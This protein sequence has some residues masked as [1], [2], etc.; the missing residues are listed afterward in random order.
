MT[1]TITKPANG[2]VLSVDNLDGVL[3]PIGASGRVKYTC[4][5]VSKKYLVLGAN[6]GS[7]YFFERKPNALLTNETLQSNFEI[8]SLNEIRDSIFSIK[9]APCNDNL[10][11]M[12]T[13]K[14]I[15]VIEPN[16]A[17]DKGRRREK[18]KQLFKIIDHPREAEI[19]TI[20]WSACGG[21]LF[22]GDDLGNI[23]CSSVA[24]GRSSHFIL[25]FSADFVTKCDSRLVQLDVIPTTVADTFSILA[26]SLTKSVVINYTISHSQTG[27]VISQIQVGKKLREKPT[28]Q[29]ACYHP[30]HNSSIYASR[31]GKRIWL[32][33]PV[34]GTVLST[35]N[36]KSGGEEGSVVVT[37]VPLAADTVNTP[38]LPVTA[39]AFA[40]LLPYGMNLISWDEKSLILIDV[41]EVEVIEWRVDST[42]IQDICI[43]ENAIYILHGQHR[44]ISR[45][46]SQ[47]LI[48]ALPIPTTITA[49]VEE[50]HS[51]QQQQPQ[52][53]KPEEIHSEPIQ[54]KQQ[55]QPQQSYVNTL[56]FSVVESDDSKDT[57]ATY[58]DQTSNKDTDGSQLDSLDT[59]SLTNSTSSLTIDDTNEQNQ[60]SVLPPST[61][62]TATITTP[63][64][65]SI[66]T[67]TPTPATTTTTPPPA[68][69]SSQHVRNTSK[70]NIFSEIE[71]NT[72][73]LITTTSSGVTK[74]II[75]KKKAKTSDSST[76][77]LKTSGSDA[78]TPSPV[79]P[80]NNDQTATISIAKDPSTQASSWAN[81]NVFDEVQ[82][83][84]NSP[85]EPSLD[86]KHTT[87]TTVKRTV[88]KK[89]L[90]KKEKTNTSSSSINDS[91]SSLST[92]ENTSKPASPTKPEQPPHPQPIQEPTTTATPSLSHPP[93]PIQPPHPTQET[94]A[95]TPQ[96]PI[97]AAASKA[98]GIFK[99]LSTSI[100]SIQQKAIT[101]I[102]KQTSEIKSE[103]TS[104]T[105]KLPF[106]SNSSTPASST[107]PTMEP[108]VEHTTESTPTVAASA[109]TPAPIQ[110]VEPIPEPTP[111]E[112]LEKLTKGTYDSWI[113]Y[114]FKRNEKAF[115]PMLQ[116]WLQSFYKVEYVAPSEMINEIITGCFL[117]GVNMLV[118]DPTGKLC[119][120]W[121]ESS[122]RETIRKYFTYLD[123]NKVYPYVNERQWDSCI[124]TILEMEAFSKHGS[125]VIS[126]L[127]S[128]IDNND[129]QG[130]IH[131]LETQKDDVGLLFRYMERLFEL[132]PK[133]AATFYAN[134]YPVILPRNIVKL[135]DQ[136]P[137]VRLPIK[138]EYLNQLLELVEECKYDSNL[139]EEW[140]TCNLS[141]NQPPKD[142]LFTNEHRP[143]VGAH[144]VEWK[145]AQQLLSIIGGV[146]TNEYLCD[147]SKLE[148]LCESNGFFEGL[149]SI[150]LHHY[151]Q[152]SSK[153]VTFHEQASLE[154]ARKLVHLVVSTDNVDGLTNL[155]ENNIDV[156]LWSMLVTKMQEHRDHYF[157]VF[158]SRDTKFAISEVLVATMMGRSI[159]P[160]QTIDILIASPLF[161]STQIPSNLLSEWVRNG[162]WALYNRKSIS[163]E[164]LSRLD[165]YLWTKKP[166]NLSPQIWS[167]VDQD[168]NNFHSPNSLKSQQQ[169]Q[170][171]QL[172][173]SSSSI[174]SST[175]NELNLGITPQFFEDSSFH[176]GTET[177]IHSG[178]CPICTLPLVE[179]P[180]STFVG[181]TPS[182]VVI[183]PY[184]GHS[185]HQYCIEEQGCLL[186]YSQKR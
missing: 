12:A 175:A 90:V 72:N 130:C 156:G 69:S 147:L 114:K 93:Q 83:K 136:N 115:F 16:L 98:S 64:N 37:P 53:Q 129:G 66:P 15:Y 73:P 68:A 1:T 33:D 2:Y 102:Q 27:K 56:T 106:G 52:Q 20:V 71:V 166:M 63:P 18:E 42:A 164:I 61:A 70:E 78:V 57:T 104:I 154:Y 124:D 133:Q 86:P 135:V 32:A 96:Q 60:E 157:N 74:K 6:T 144:N 168:F 158:Y 131:Y 21:Y 92:P 9:L 138:F 50:H 141:F 99:G 160:L 132:Q 162:K 17:A 89:K 107:P 80:T 155:M 125:K 116:I 177:E 146:M 55:Q 4:F 122:A 108:I 101:K 8:L 5:D 84:G 58:S 112:V 34:E 170:N 185:Y 88:V 172:I 174:T 126:T 85:M 140:F 76:N 110:P 148:D 13:N 150:Y 67:V 178:Q 62:T 38:M 103:L 182:S 31:P 65:V 139:V 46:Y 7:L 28:K 97:S 19:T 171:N 82:S 152:Y 45:V 143:R 118:Q 3:A 145:N 121:N 169:Q 10:V 184:C 29:G 30:L 14:I 100:E 75:K 79:S 51:T 149:L 41:D 109:P 25:R 95:Q 22:S 173:D 119:M 94:S 180:E 81:V 87:T 77:L 179:N 40:R 159:G 35:M 161:E 123:C 181:V 151:K 167:L 113:I 120:C 43:H 137:S 105:Q 47:T 117:C 11:A 49:A 39:M 48:S 36:F 23:Y 134:R 165:S 44:S 186:C 91:A 142:Q 111:L 163:H 183:F 176:W 127:N 59:N 128:F 153:S 54:S 26:S 24:K